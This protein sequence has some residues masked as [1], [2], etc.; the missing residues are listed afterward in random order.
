MKD[1]DQRAPWNAERFITTVNADVVTW[2]WTPGEL[3]RMRSRVATLTE[4]LDRCSGSSAQ[5][6]WRD[7]EASIWPEWI[8]GR[9]RPGGDLWRWGTWGAVLTQAVQPG[10]EFMSTGRISQWSQRLPCD[11]FLRRAS[12]QLDTMLGEVGWVRAGARMDARWLGLRLL[13][14]HGITK[15]EE[16]TDAHLRI[17]GRVKGMDALD[18]SLCNIGVLDRAPMR[19]STRWSR[20]RQLSPAEIVDIAR[21]PERF[22]VV[23]VQYLEEYRVRIAPVY[24]TM[25]AKGIALGH[26]WRYIEAE[27]PDVS[28]CAEVRPRH[29][30]GFLP[31][32]RA[33]AESVRRRSAHD[34]G[35]HERTT[36]HQWVVEVKTFFADLTSWVADDDSPLAGLAPAFNPVGRRDLTSLEPVKIRRQTQARIAATVLEL[37]RELPNIRAHALRR[38]QDAKLNGA[39]P[40]VGQATVPGEAAAFWDW[41]LLELLVLSG[42]RVEEACELTTLD[43]LRRRLPDGRRYFLL[44]VKPSKYDRAR[45][46]PIGDGLGRIIPEMVRHVRTF[47]GADTIPPVRSWD[48]HEKRWNPTAP[49]LLQTA[50]GHPSVI[51]IGT[52][53]N[54]LA[55]LSR[56][57]GARRS[58]GRQLVLRP[59][60]C[61]RMFA[62]EHLNNSTP[63]HVIQALLGHATIDTV[64]IYAKLYPTTLV[65]EYR[66]TLRGVYEARYGSEAFKNPS[67]GEWQALDQ[68]CAMRDMGTHLCALPIG[69]HCPKG[70]VCLGCS[71]A[72]PKRSAVPAF[73]GMLASHLRVL[74]RA[75]EIGEPAGQVAARELEVERIRSALRRAEELSTD[76]AAL[77]EATA[78]GN[79]DA[80]DDG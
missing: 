50:A 53:R 57:A 23:T 18:A 45:V 54:R 49:Y 73:R 66:K 27:H 30:R 55:G 65:D 68:A 79:T 47:Y 41:A 38:W 77:I 32:A 74:H 44:H 34:D 1:R 37:E 13:L 36:A 76:V 39:P 80:S 69:E 10:W 51:D 16:L 70:L 17:T 15:V 46:I 48:S 72:Q 8:A 26:W 40:Q 35:T 58:D 61:R 71:H 5:D 62:S 11:H 60:D 24:T 52:I 28:S 25:R 43:V 9:G 31:W 12:D 14:V 33:R 6:R 56:A 78:S 19:G 7:F 42:L 21:V 22:R 4:V 20:R 75:R 3:N 59:H 67:T 2:R 63:P 64:L 29:A